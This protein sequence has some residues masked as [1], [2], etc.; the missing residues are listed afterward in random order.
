MLKLPVHKNQAGF[1]TLEILLAFL[2]LSFSIA[3]IIN[4]VYGGQSL[5]IDSQ[6]NSEAQHKAQAMLEE[7]RASSTQDFA[8]VVPLP[9]PPATSTQDGIYSKSLD[10]QPVDS[11][12]EKVT[13][14]ITWQASGGRNQSVSLSTLLTNPSAAAGGGGSCSVVITG[15]WKSPNIQSYEF[16]RDIL[17][18]TSSGFPIT[19]VE[20]DNGKLYVTVNNSNGNNFPTLFILDI[21]TPSQ[22]F[23]T[24]PTVLQSMD[25]DP[26]MKTGLNAV[27]VSG[28]YAYA[29]KATGPSSGQLQ[30]IDLTS[31]TVVST[32]KIPGVTGSGSQSIG[33]S[34]FYRNGVVFLGLA[35]TPDSTINDTEF[36]VIDVGG[37]GIVGA[38]P[39]NPIRMGGY[40]VHNGINAI[41]VK[42]NYAYIATPNAEEL[43]VLDISTLS[44]PHRAGGFNAPGGSG[45]GKSIYLVG[46]TLYL[47]R[48]V[49]NQEF[50]ILNDSV[51]ATNQLPSLG[52]QDINSSV[53]GVLVRNYL[54][55]LLTNSQF[56]IWKIDN[57][58]SITPWTT[59]GTTADFVN[60]PA[61]SGTAVGCTG[62]YIFIGSL[63]SN[64]KGY[65]SIITGS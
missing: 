54:A 6:T 21:S 56:E 48:T 57:P 45:N 28:N 22:W 47:G 29:A 13:S 33:Q 65:L 14:N 16:G 9:V 40:Q 5:A 17:H 3:A 2:V 38:S 10:I 37:G 7:A 51:P 50:Y 52:V 15:N 63:P 53:N 31:L 19:D 20:A 62:N 64:N 24:T 8:S 27:T 44:N 4:L 23:T 36:N 18:D 34:I 61:G 55:F 59:S 49:G 39:T 25:N 1:S 11:Y 60:L 35:K 12:T 42:N 46:N 30:V 32:Y 26:T 58:A 41:Y 43:T